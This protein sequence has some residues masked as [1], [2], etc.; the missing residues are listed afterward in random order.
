M[1]KEDHKNYRNLIVSIV[2]NFGNSSYELDVSDVY[3]LFK[4]ND[5]IYKELK[6]SI[7]SLN[8]NYK[9]QTNNAI[10]EMILQNE[11]NYFDIY[12]ER[13]NELKKK[14]DKKTCVEIINDMSYS[15]KES[16]KKK[17][18]KFNVEVIDTNL[19]AMENILYFILLEEII[20][21]GNYNL[22][23]G[24]TS[25]LKNYIKSIKDNLIST[26]EKNE[27]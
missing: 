26:D 1:W 23:N 14:V 7:I 10:Y 9:Y 25:N 22:I 27:F 17:P 18:F 19:S 11:E 6:N 20:E 8:M 15:I 3:Q 12:M 13:L 4:K 16:I 24:E 2:E 21:I 5:K